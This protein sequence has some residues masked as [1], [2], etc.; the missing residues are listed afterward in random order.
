M[1]YFVLGEKLPYTYSPEI[2]SKFGLDYGKVELEKELLK[3]FVNDKNFKGFNVTVPYKV[4][5]IDL[6]NHVL[7]DAK[8]VGAVNTVVNRAGV[9]YGYNTDIG[10]LEYGLKKL[11]IEVCGKNCAIL[12]TGGT[13]KTAEFVLKKMGAK[14]IYKV[15]RTSEINYD[16]IYDLKINVLINTTPVGTFPN[17]QN[18]LVDLEKIKGLESVFDVV[19]NPLETELIRRAKALK[20]KA[21]NGLRM[22]VEQGRLAENLFLDKEIPLEKT[23]EIVQSFYKSK[24]NIV[25]IGMP[26]S[27]KSSV[28]IAL[29]KL[30]NRKLIDLD[31]EICKKT[32]LEIPEIFARYG[33]EYFRKVEEEVVKEVSGQF[34]LVIATGG[35]A[36]V[37]KS[38][39]NLLTRNGALFYIKRDLSKLVDDG[40]P[41]SI[42]RGNE[43]IYAE[44]KAIYEKADFTVEN[45][46]KTID[47]VAKE[48]A[49]LYEKNTNY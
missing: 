10:G 7:G 15:G 4:S 6:L 47:E 46:D 14:V 29:A 33:E 12:G 8:Q 49:Y 42:S 1:D 39:F 24:K 37:S 26:S 2:H 48:I 41:N 32:G 18:C 35:G 25:L 44:R 43:I 20:L 40:R 13:S 38:N 31:S 30:L 21:G 17:M 23:E 28:G 16:N 45:N 34:S 19:Y 9:L 27:G 22:L 3:Q 5:I 11:N 36:V